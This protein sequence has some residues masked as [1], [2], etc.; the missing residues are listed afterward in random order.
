MRNAGSNAWVSP[1]H[2]SASRKYQFGALQAERR[3]LIEASVHLLSEQSFLSLETALMVVRHSASADAALKAVA[4]FVGS[5]WNTGV[6]L[7]V[8]GPVLTPLLAFGGVVHPQALA[9]VALSVEG[10]TPISEAARAPAVLSQ[11]D[12]DPLLSQL[13]CG[14]RDVGAMVMSVP[15]GLDVRYVLYAC[16]P[17]AEDNYRGSYA[18]LL[19]ELGTTLSRVAQWPN[20]NPMLAVTSSVP[21]SRP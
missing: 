16:D 20:R 10:D 14:R 7:A 15:Q 21:D 17:L 12:P 19:H 4:R 3:L 9:A 13:L 5:R 6:L 8:E 2:S 18:I 11:A 1:T